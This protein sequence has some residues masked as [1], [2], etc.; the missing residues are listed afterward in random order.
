MPIFLSTQASK[1]F[2]AGVLAFLAAVAAA[3]P[4][5][6]TTQSWI[7]A[8]V[9]GLVAYL[10]TYNIPNAGP[11]DPVLAVNPVGVAPVAPGPQDSSPLPPAV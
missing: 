3:Q 2:A 8:V 4:S 1:A 10:G 11:S 7:T 5:G 6:M 9:T